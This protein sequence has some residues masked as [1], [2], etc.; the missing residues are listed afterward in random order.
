[1][2]GADGGIVTEVSGAS[3]IV[4]AGALTEDTT[5]RIA[6]D[7][8]GAPALPSDLTP[9]GDVYVITPH[10]GEF[11]A[12]VEVRI[13]APNVTLQPNQLFKIAKAEPGG[14][15]VVNEDTIL[16]QGTLSTTVNSFSYF[17]VVVVTYVLPI[18]EAVPLE[19]TTS[20]SCAGGTCSG[21]IGAVTATYT[22][23]GN[24]GQLPQDCANFRL[25]IFHAAFLSYYSSTQHLQISPAGGSVTITRDPPPTT[26]ESRGY[27]FGV[28]RRCSTN[29]S[30]SQF[31]YSV[32][33]HI[34]WANWVGYPDLSMARMPQQVDVVEGHAA[35]IEA[36][37][38]GGATELVG[39]AYRGPTRTDR[40]LID[41][42]R[43][44]DNGASW[45]VIAN[46]YQ[47]EANS[48]PGGVGVP[49]RYW[50]VSHGFVA[51]VTDQGAL[52][53]VHA[54][55]T[56]PAGGEQKCITSANA[57]LNVLQQSALPSIVDAPR[58][59][60]VRTGQTASLLATA[61]GLPAPALQWQTRPANSSDAWSDVTSGTGPTTANYTTAATTLAD[62][63]AQYRVV[64]TNAVG[65]VASTAVTVSVSDLDVAPT[66]TTQPANLS[67]AAGG[68]AV[69]A[70]DARGTEALSYQW[71]RN[72]TAL[73]GA[74][75]PVLRL[76]GVTMLNSGSFSVTVSNPAG[77]ADS[78]AATLNVYPAAP[79][80]VAPGIVTQ[81]VA[82]TVN[83][84][85][86]A[87]FAVGVDGTGPFTF[88][89]RKDGVDIAGATSAVLTLPAVTAA[90]A[91]DYAVV[92]GN[93][94]SS[95]VQSSSATLTVNPA[96]VAAAP[97]ITT[98]PATLIVAPGGSGMLAVAATGSGSLSYQWLADGVP[99]GGETS[100]VLPIN[101][102]GPSTEGRYAVRVSNNIGAVVSNEVQVILLGAP[103][104]T[105]HPA[106]TTALE[107]AT[108]T[109]AVAANSSGLRYQWL[110]NGLAIG[111][112]TDS[113]YTTASLTTAD[114]GAVYSVI[115]Y[116]GAGVAMSQ[117]AVLTVLAF[118]PPTVTEDPVNTSVLAGSAA[119]LCATFA[120]TPPFDVQMTRWSGTAWLPVLALRR[121]FDNARA[122]TTTPVLQLSDSGT[123][124]R[125][126]LTSG[127]GNAYQATTNVAIITVTAPPTGITAT[128]L[129]SRATSGATADNASGLPSISAD[130]NLVAF[131]TT[132]TN[133]VP[134]FTNPPTEMGH[135][136]LRNIATGV[137]TAIDQTP[138]GTQSSRGVSEVKLAAGGRYVVFSSLAG[139]LVVDD[140]NGSE[141]V[142]VRDLQTGITT[143]ISLHADGSQITD[144][145]N[146][147][148]TV[149]ADISADGRFVSFVSMQDLI[150]TNP[151]S[152]FSLYL[153]DMQTGSL[154]RVTGS[155]DSSWIA[156]PVMSSNGA[157]LAYAYTNFAPASAV[158]KLYDV[159]ANVTSELYRL[160]T[161][162]GTAWLG[163]GLS[164]SGNGRFVSFAVRSPAIFNGSTF[165]QILAIDRADPDHI[166][167]AS[168]GSF[169]VGD[170]GSSFPKVSDD[171][172]VLFATV[173]PNLTGNIANSSRT[174]LV[175][176]DL[177]NSDV[178]PAL[179][180][181]D[182]SVVWTSAVYGEH[183]MSSDGTAFALV[184]PEALLSSGNNGLQVFV[185]PRP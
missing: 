124:F 112:A 9:A 36:I 59:V 66:I 53:R 38:T 7:S 136:Y 45:R 5:I 8:T 101:N 75:S 92:I 156:D 42:E 47:D 175:V 56:P 100:A 51:S 158:V 111:N 150:G 113:S 161:T 81:P 25:D 115:V 148:G 142:F 18:A 166:T 68:D 125:F 160:D 90:S 182:G 55:Y 57:R 109:F 155:T 3:V 169:G 121:L 58:S 149:H 52:L 88:Q 162:D 178:I 154:R 30:W 15:W 133:L 97:A 171:G 64:A 2:I 34:T 78:N 74:N 79:A 174:V 181:P 6:K 105:Q 27:E 37:L 163:Q 20:L 54:C 147:T 164:I 179:R 73:P 60:L 139:D 17:T 61:A 122:C 48:L 35:N 82:V 31:G 141:D 67:V 177:Q 41:W 172:H 107:N 4:P 146:G 119:T 71:F 16:E 152:T 1:M 24:G 117:G 69:F 167:T 126:E 91:G 103:F 168:G 33:R 138:A 95:G 104:I 180:Q 12:G 114:S 185:A 137:T 123:M 140:T 23:T 44:D 134:G 76:T 151:P 120:G 173:A 49:W 153:R 143:R 159:E 110:R 98:Q 14:E 130:G 11:F 127:P 165:P 10:G 157:Y 106:D 80:A 129:A 94:A 145:G 118:T 86:T 43:S 83:A 84:G 102:A 131:T 28:A 32:R 96:S 87:T 85:N 50:S 22:V 128:T 132:G 65:S 176:R 29:G 72:G 116:N 93:A 144:A 39:T 135:A 184:A 46:S 170:G 70:I 108:A 40:A 63:G 13:P 62:N 19:V 26:T 77:D 99:L 89:W 183:A 21:Q